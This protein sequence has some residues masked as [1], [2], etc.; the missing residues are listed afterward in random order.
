MADRPNGRDARARDGAAR[1]DRATVRLNDR[2][3]IVG[4]AGSGKSVLLRSL[5]R[6]YSRAVLIDYKG[7]D[8]LPDWH[9]SRGAAEFVR[10]FPARST[11]VV[12]Q[13][14]PFEDSVEWFD[15]V[16]RHAF[17]IGAVAV[18]I[19]ELPPELTVG[20]QKSPGL[21]VLYK[22]GRSRQVLPIGCVQ[23]SYAIPLVMLSEAT[24]LYVFQLL[25]PEDRKRIRD[26]IGEFPT[27]RSKHGFVYA[28]PGLGAAVEC[29]P[30][31]I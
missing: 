1:V 31:S 25:L 27:P 19:D 17:R 16:C 8:P 11:R 14:A 23:R 15:R 24:Q 30:L 9:H 6:R 18:G 21:E 2:V 12:A 7:D 22:Q 26:V 13:Q 29:A 10:D 28:Q 20:G 4:R 3:T 5:I